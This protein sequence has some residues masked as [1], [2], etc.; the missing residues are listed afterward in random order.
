MNYYRSYRILVILIFSGIF[1][2]TTV[3][4]ANKGE[5]VW[6]NMVYKE[7]I[8]SVLLYKSG[9]EL[10]MPV[11]R[12]NTEEKLGL[13]FDEIGRKP[14]SY[15]YTIFHCKPDWTISGL[16]PAD[17]MEG[18][19]SGTID[20]YEF[21]KNTMVEYVNYQLDFPDYDFKI[22]ISGNYIIKVYEDENPENLVLTARFYVLE[23]MVTINGKVEKLK[24]TYEEGL[25][26]QVNFDA[27]FNT[28]IINPTATTSYTF[29]KNNETQKHFSQLKPGSITG[30]K[31]IFE[32][33]KDL[34][35]PGGNEYRNLDLK[36]FKFISG[37]IDRI[38]KGTDAHHVYLK[39][40]ITRQD[41][42]YT[43]E[44]DLNGRRLIKLENN[45]RSN[46][47][48]DYCY[49]YFELEPLSAV[50]PGAYHIF[51]AI[52]NWYSN[53][54][55]NPEFNKD[56]NSWSKKIFLKQGYYNYLYMFRSEDRLFARE[57][58]H[59][60]FEGNHFQT[61]NDYHLFIYYKNY[62]DNYSRLIGYKMI[63]SSE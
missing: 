3:G 22:L 43:A 61:E 33:N 13:R 28:E 55:F 54:G 35:F 6:N 4:Q 52:S 49:V 32:R 17:F 36:N 7:N 62:N 51:G 31:L 8:H 14:N 5:T 12:L 44:K 50:E 60:R 27:I 39:K 1:Y 37:Q 11:I 26:Q 15:R 25:N 34:C 63:N 58:D 18:Q 41:E 16:E 42:K 53:D 46:I 24:I 9:W 19:Y 38:V 10:S 30:N 59:Y 40:E 57:S 23:P 20:T 47:M 56:R 21:S 48:A 45:N 2:H 29:I